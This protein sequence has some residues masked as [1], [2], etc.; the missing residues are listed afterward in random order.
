[1]RVMRLSCSNNNIAVHAVQ[2]MAVVRSLSHGAAMGL[3]SPR[4]YID[5]VAIRRNG[6]GGLHFSYCESHD[7]VLVIQWPRSISAPSL[8]QNIIY[9]HGYRLSL[10]RGSQLCSWDQ[11]PEHHDVLPIRRVSFTSIFY[12]E[13]LC[14][15]G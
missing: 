10:S 4:E 3:I 14:T 6:D 5:L 7:R 8:S 13:I 11:S 1:M 15:V 9:S 12:S 2:D